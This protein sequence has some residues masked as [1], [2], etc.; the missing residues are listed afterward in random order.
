V[1]TELAAPLCARALLSGAADS[2]HFI[3]YHDP[4]PHLRVRLHG[5]PAR[6]M[7]EVL[8][9]LHAAAAPFFADGRLCGIELVGYRREIAR[10]GGA[11]GMQL[12][13]R[14]FQVDSEAVAQ[15]VGSI[16]PS[17]DGASARWRLALR[18]IDGLLGDLGLA[19]AARLA[20]MR[21]VRARHFAVTPPLA[22]ELEARFRGE[23]DLLAA[24]LDPAG[25]GGALADGLAVFAR[26][27]A[28]LAPLAV[29]L[30]AAEAAGRLTRPIVEQA[31]SY[32]HMFANRLLR[33]QALAQERVLY[34]FLHRLYSGE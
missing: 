11:D 5:E 18:G 12:A 19:R 4:D 20:V 21:S 31:A 30:R 22:V 1:L 9:D 25:D 32:I 29:E 27:S 23:R 17:D 33:S 24:L 15:L 2:W 7:G 10:Y 13:E 16:D 28:R 3:R 6:L 14:I 26:R 34:D 8:A